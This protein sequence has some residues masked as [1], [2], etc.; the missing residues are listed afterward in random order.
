MRNIDVIRVYF[1]DN[2]NKL[3]FGTKNLKIDYRFWKGISLINYNTVILSRESWSG[4]GIYTLNITK[5]S[6]STS[7]IQAQIKQIAKELNIQLIYTEV[8]NF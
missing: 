1:T 7:K 2:F 8:E 6:R 5:Y 4:C 3:P